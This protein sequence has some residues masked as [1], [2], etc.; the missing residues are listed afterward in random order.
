MEYFIYGIKNIK[1]SKMYIGST[2]SFNKRK[3]YH[4]YL[5]KKNNHHST[6]LQNSYNMYGKDYFEFIILEKCINVNTNRKEKELYY[7]NLYQSFNREFGY[8][9]YKPNDKDFMCADETIKKLKN[10]KYIKKISVA[11]DA[12]DL[13]GNLISK[14]NSIKEA[15]ILL[16]IKRHLIIGIINKKRKSYKGI[17]FVLKDN[18][19]DY[20]PSSKQRNMSKFYKLNNIV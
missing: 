6:H 17:T 4:N 13:S 20:I 3:Y 12:Y 18:F 16:K 7:I 11:V 19:F 2:K 1:N 5:L 15:S 9:Y 14:Y 8:N 10:T